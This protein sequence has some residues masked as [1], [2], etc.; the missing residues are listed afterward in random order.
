MRRGVSIRKLKGMSPARQEREISALLQEA[1]RAPNGELPRLEA[2]IQAFEQR[3]GFA[4]DTLRQRV[5]SGEERET[6]DFCRW[7][8]FARLRDRLVAQARPK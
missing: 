8:M 3:Y 4:T 1:R 6:D 7:L 5:A 2:V